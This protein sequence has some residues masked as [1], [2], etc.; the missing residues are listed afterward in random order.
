M[1]LFTTTLS[2]QNR[3]EKPI[4]INLNASGL[5]LKA[6]GSTIAD[7]EI[8]DLEVNNWVAPGLSIG[9][10]LNNR[11]YVG[12]SFQP[13]RN[14]ILKEPWTFGDGENDG[15]I[16]LD[17]NTGSFH[18]LEGRYFPFNFGLYGALFLTHVSEGKYEMEF[19]SEESGMAIGEN[20]YNTDLDAEWNARALNTIGFG[21][22]Y[23][24]V[25]RSGFS[26]DL[27]LGLPIPNSKPLYENITV[28]SIQGIT[29]ESADI[30]SAETKIE[31]ELFY[32]PV[33]LHLN[34]GYNLGRLNRGH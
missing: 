1:L 13:N 19:K 22:G 28:S 29:I 32:F 18:S 2:A 16:S 15:T 4:Q 10:H 5:F 8:T 23:N 33:Q 12:Y 9:Y 7:S 26:F 30:T 31:N 11:I 3:T 34:L 27:G 25:H 20:I 17:H 21:L 6:L 24:Y 14:L